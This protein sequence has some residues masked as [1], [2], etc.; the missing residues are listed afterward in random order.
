MV[1]PVVWFARAVVNWRSPSVAKSAYLLLYDCTTIVGAW[2]RLL[3]G[4]GLTAPSGEKNDDDDDDDD[5]DNDDDDDDDDDDND[6]DDDVKDDDIEHD[7]DE[8]DTEWYLQ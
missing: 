6:D 3:P 2:N 1:K 8:C 4:P 5:D 7:D